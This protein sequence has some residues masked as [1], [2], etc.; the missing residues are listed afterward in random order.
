MALHAP[1]F[2]GWS[3]PLAEGVARTLLEEAQDS[4]QVVRVRGQAVTEMP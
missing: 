2:I 1:K 3:R 4:W